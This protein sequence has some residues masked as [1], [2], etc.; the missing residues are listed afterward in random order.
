MAAIKP[1]GPGFN[2]H[3]TAKRGA[4]LDG[5]F[6]AIDAMDTDRFVEYLTED[7][8]F[9]FG[10]APPVRGRD[11]IAAAVNSF[12]A[13]IAA[14][15]H[16]VSRVWSDADSVCCEGEV[17]Y[18]RHDNSEIVIPFVDVFELDNGNISAYKIYIDIGPLF[19]S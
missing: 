10:S 3:A 1:S 17:C 16:S 2:V 6:G 14:L 4:F 7:C 12:Y 13:S 9:R 18:Q 5:L 11:A 8:V 19:P 15:S